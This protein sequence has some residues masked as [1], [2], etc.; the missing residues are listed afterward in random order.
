MRFAARPSA[1]ALRYRDTRLTVSEFDR[2]CD[3]LALRLSG[4]DGVIAVRASGTPESVALL[5]G[6]LRASKPVALIPAM[7]TA[8]EVATYRRLLGCVVEVDAQ[9]DT[10]WCSGDIPARHHPD[11][12]LILFTSG[13]TGVPRAVQVSCNHLERHMK[14]VYQ[15]IDLASAR[16]MAVFVPLSYAF[17]V[18]G[19]VLPA[20]CFG[21][22]VHL[23]A[24]VAEARSI[25][26]R[27]EA[28]GVWSAVPAQ[29]EALLRACRP[30]PENFTG[31][32]HAVS[33]GA[34]LFPDLRRRLAERMPHATLYNSYGQTEAGP[35]LLS[36][37]SRD[38]RFFTAATG[39]PV[40]GAELS[41]GPSGELSVRGPLVMLGYVGDE[42]PRKPEDW[43]VTG[44]LASVDGDGLYTLLGRQDDIRKV[45]G[46]RISLIEVDAAL[47]TLPGIADAAADTEED[48]LYGALLVAYVVLRKGET[49]PRTGDLR[50]VMGRTLAWHKVPQRFFALPALP[51]SG[52]GKLL[53]R[54]LPARRATAREL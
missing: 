5:V 37:N 8:P 15:T 4:Y 32:S 45:G 18:M 26:E 51:R 40:H 28:V 16:A 35:R 54:D 53:R 34:P 20:L 10:I 43:H 19:Q 1:T 17:G 44:D 31:I 33:A 52:N 39:F 23:M 21:I 42:P 30:L 41:L 25:I 6:G 27:G 14:N 24:N 11:A 50:D 36:L 3:A 12:S 7:A 29:W 46:T 38:P 9:G 2:R 22:E 13:S 49:P 47:R 48:D